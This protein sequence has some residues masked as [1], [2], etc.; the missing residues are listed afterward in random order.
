[1]GTAVDFFS[2]SF[3]SVGRKASGSYPR[4][5]LELRV[6]SPHWAVVKKHS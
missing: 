6:H 2:L 3:L 1:M 5:A 4:A